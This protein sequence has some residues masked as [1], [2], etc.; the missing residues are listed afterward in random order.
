MIESLIKAGALDSLAPRRAQLFAAVEGAMESG[1]KAWR[2]RENG[3]AGLFAEMLAE[4]PSE[5]P[6]PDVPE[7][8]S[9][10][11]LLGEKEVLGFYVTGHPLE[12][13]RDKIADLA[14]HFTDGLEGLDRGVEVSLCGVLTGMQRR[15]NNEGKPWA[16]MQLEDLSG[17][18]D[19]V[20]FTT[21]YERLLEFIVEDKAVLLRGLVLPEEGAPPKISVQ[22]LIPLE[23]AGVNYPSLVSIRVPL[24]R[25]PDL[26][27]ALG[28]LFKTKPGETSVRL[29]LE[30][31]RDFSLLLDVAQKVKPD[32]E[33]QAEVARLCG[34][35]AF[36]VLA[37]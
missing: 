6:L 35:E 36:E 21:N 10:Q 8:T 12:Q 26:P 23:V 27:A 15:R 18:I 2:D 4:E 32:R 28:D 13:F 22:D 31:P 25:S 11:R 3:Q 9:E 20:L 1:Q 30:K 34:S 33:F 17:A 29:R 14:S 37:K 16:S 24:G 7:W 19:C 5:R